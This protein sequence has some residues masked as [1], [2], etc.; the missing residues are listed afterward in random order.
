MKVCGEGRVPRLLRACS[1]GVP[2]P[3]AN[4]TVKFGW[5]GNLTESFLR[6]LSVSVVFKITTGSR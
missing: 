3:V 1:W 4:N 5:L 2:E 6:S